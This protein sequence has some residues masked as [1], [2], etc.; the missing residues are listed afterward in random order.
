MNADFRPRPYGGD[1][2]SMAPRLWHEADALA[3][4]EPLL[5][6]M[7]RSAVG[8]DAGMATLADIL[9]RVLA[10]RLSGPDIATSALEELFRH[11]YSVAQALPEWAAL[12]IEAVLRRDP[13]TESALSVV[14]YQKGFQAIQLHRVTHVLWEEG[15]KDLALYLQSL[16]SRVLGVDIHP[17][18][19]IGHGVMFDH[20]TGIVIG[21][22]TVIGNGVS[23]MQGV[24]LGGTGKMKGDRHPKIGEGVLIGAGAVLLG[25]ITVGAHAKVGAGSV[26]LIDVA[27][28]TT[29][30]GV[31]AQEVSAAT[32]KQPAEEMDQSLS[33][34]ATKRQPGR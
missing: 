21:E 29:V 15:R 26:V 10:R 33:D 3:L 30:A 11:V 32:L 34:G 27:P 23:V 14:L 22:T 5:A 20:A 24:T 18:C 17:A 13:A 19:H 2:A 12:D 7:C 28:Q 8:D 25:N 16:G 6:Q 1:A 31:P 9:A 4:R